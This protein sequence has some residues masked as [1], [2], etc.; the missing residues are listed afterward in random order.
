[1]NPVLYQADEIVE[2]WSRITA[3]LLWVEGADTDVTKWWGDRYPRSDF[4][5]RL[6]RVPLVEQER[7]ADCGHMLHHDQPEA[8]AARLLR[9]LSAG[10]LGSRAAAMNPEASR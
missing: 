8:L 5:A 4:E 10:R 6:A 3:P 2:T 9:F 7:L 1:M